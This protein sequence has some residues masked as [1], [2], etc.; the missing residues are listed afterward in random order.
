MDTK[1]FLSAI[2]KFLIGFVVVGLLIF[3]PAGTIKFFNG[4]LFMGLLFIP[5]FIGGI[6]LFFL[7][8]LLLKNRL[9]AKEKESEQKEVL[10]LSGV[11]FILG[12]IISGLNYRYN[13]TSLPS[14]VVIIASVL[15][16]ISYILYGEV[17]RENSFLLR[18]IEVKDNQ[19]LVDTGLYGIVRHP[20]Y[21]IT[22]V[23][24]LMIPLIL[25]SIISFVIFLVYPFII[26]K[27]IKNEEKVL[28]KQLKGYKD[29]KK[30]VKYRLIP[31]IW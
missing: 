4:L 12:F 14:F 5:M 29:Y 11:M 15:F 18:T 9:N 25:N 31:F 10:F 21:A 17:L 13:W 3:I 23:L 1:L 27:R 8:P 6:I 28:E 24:F 19:K 16:I 26:V 2:I 7:D 20:M 22:I 30:K